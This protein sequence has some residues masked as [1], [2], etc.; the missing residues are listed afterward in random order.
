MPDLKSAFGKG[1]GVA[2]AGHEQHLVSGAQ[3]GRSEAAAHASHSD[4]RKT[5]AGYTARFCVF[6]Q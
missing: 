6:S 5:H 3:Q 4:D 2:A 1:L